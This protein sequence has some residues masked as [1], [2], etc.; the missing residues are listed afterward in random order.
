MKYLFCFFI[1][2]TSL[3]LSSCKNEIDSPVSTKENTLTQTDNDCCAFTVR[4][5]VQQ[6]NGYE[7]VNCVDR[8][9]TTSQKMIPNC[10]N[11]YWFVTYYNMEN[12][13]RIICNYSYSISVESSGYFGIY[14]SPNPN[15]QPVFYKWLPYDPDQSYVEG[16]YYIDNLVP[17]NP[18]Y[19]AIL[20]VHPVVVEE[21]K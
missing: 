21:N 6:Y 17:G 2:F 11:F 15:T 13:Y 1:V 18:G 10:D 9:F 12:Y 20:C 14:E 5:I 19:Y 8:T 7:Y 3:F 16:T 4:M